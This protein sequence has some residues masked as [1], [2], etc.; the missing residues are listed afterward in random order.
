MI[1]YT[2]LHNNLTVRCMKCMQ[3]QYS[4]YHFIN[5]CKVIHTGV[6]SSVHSHIDYADINNSDCDGNTDNNKDKDKDDV[7]KV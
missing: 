5:E 2:N 3:K 1:H 6:I 4:G 7:N